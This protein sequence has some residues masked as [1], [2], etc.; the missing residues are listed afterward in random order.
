[1]N[2]RVNPDDVPVAIVGIV[3]A[4]V[5]AE[6]GAIEVGDLLTRRLRQSVA[7]P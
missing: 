1:V 3:P 5:S 4:K 2:L 7:V 6:N